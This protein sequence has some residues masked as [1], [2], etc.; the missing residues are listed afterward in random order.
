MTIF[1]SNI[2]HLKSPGVKRY[3]KGPI[4][5]SVYYGLQMQ[6]ILQSKKISKYLMSQDQHE[7]QKML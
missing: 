7:K 5:D 2:I 6:I 4:K 3:F 1:L